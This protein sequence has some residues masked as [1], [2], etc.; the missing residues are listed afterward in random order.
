MVRGALA[1]PAP[2]SVSYLSW[3]PPIRPLFSTAANTREDRVFIMKIHSVLVWSTWFAMG[4][5]AFG[6]SKNETSFV[7]EAAGGNLAEIK[8]G[9]LATQKGT[10]PRV[11]DFGNLMIKDH[12]SANNNLKP[13]ADAGGVKWPDSPPQDAQATYDRL[14]KLS[15]DQFDHQFV[16][17]MVKDHR[18]V[19]QLYQ[20]ELG[21]ASD[22]KLKTYISDTLPVVRSHLQHAESIE[23]SPSKK[24]AS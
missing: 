20:Q 15:G 22:A 4:L 8:L 9:Q 3:I 17:V 6:L 10:D 16:D 5:T 13:I 19:A 18:K 12:T 7:T 24:K 2:V 11:K 1:L 21:K 23:K 14:S